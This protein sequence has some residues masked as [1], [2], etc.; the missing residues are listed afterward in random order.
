MLKIRRP[1]GRLIFN[2]GIA[3]PGK[4]VFLIETA[5]RPQQN[6]RKHEAFRF[7]YGIEKRSVCPLFTWLPAIHYKRLLQFKHQTYKCILLLLL[8]FSNNDIAIAVWFE[9]CSITIGTI[10][11]KYFKSYCRLNWRP[12]ELM[13]LWSIF[14][15]SGWHC[16]GFYAVTIRSCVVINAWY[17]GNC[18]TDQTVMLLLWPASWRQYVGDFVM[19]QILCVTRFV[20]L[21]QKSRWYL[22][23][24][25]G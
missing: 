25:Y 11:F 12:N 19:R 20:P 24:W 4:T 10:L 23:I 21:F 8:F 17:I 16:I 2:M 9:H 13:Y 22:G 1:L 3:I 15:S 14:I 18:D 5:P 6:T 7:V